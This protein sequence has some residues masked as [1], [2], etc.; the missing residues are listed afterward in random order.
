MAQKPL[1]SQDVGGGDGVTNLSPAREST[2]HNQ[3]GPQI[4]LRAVS[5]VGFFT[6]SLF[7][8][9]RPGRWRRPLFAPSL[10][11]GRTV[12]C[13]PCS[14]RLYLLPLFPPS[15]VGP[16]FPRRGRPG[17][18][19]RSVYHRPPTTRGSD[20]RAH[21]E[22]QASSF[23]TVRSHL[24]CYSYAWSAKPRSSLALQAS[25]GQTS[26]VRL[27]PHRWCGRTTQRFRAGH[28]RNVRFGLPATQRALCAEGGFIPRPSPTHQRVPQ[29]KLKQKPDNFGLCLATPNVCHSAAYLHVRPYFAIP[30][31]RVSVRIPPRAHCDV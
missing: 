17:W 6:S 3:N 19:Q 21:G 9:H 27:H 24:G 10:T 11:S 18:T 5:N 13:S 14:R 29:W 20:T 2:G 7:S 16:G 15:G 30:T 26:L 25:C 4:A 23:A 31:R 1:Y 12:S 8:W 28:D 22:R